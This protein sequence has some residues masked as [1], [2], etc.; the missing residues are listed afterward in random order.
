MSVTIISRNKKAEAL[1]PNISGWELYGHMH[2]ISR[3]LFYAEMGYLN[4][5][6]PRPPDKM[7]KTEC[8]RAAHLIEHILLQSDEYSVSQ[9]EEL[10]KRAKHL[11]RGSLKALVE[12][13][14]AWLKECDG[15]TID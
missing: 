7:T 13:Y 15:Y 14:V 6:I 2:L 11:Y 12:Q 3:A 1:L 4:P 8:L 9:L 10:A 5:L